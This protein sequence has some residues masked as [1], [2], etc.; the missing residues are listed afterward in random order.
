MPLGIDTPSMFAL[1]FGVV[2][3]AYVITKD[4]MKAWEVG[5]AVLLS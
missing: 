2:G 3:P 4:G 1:S 5:M